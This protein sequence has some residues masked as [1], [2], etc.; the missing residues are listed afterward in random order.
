[1]C[2]ASGTISGFAAPNTTVVISG[3]TAAGAPTELTAPRETA[4][5]PPGAP[6]ARSATPGIGAPATHFC[7]APGLAISRTLVPQ[8]VVITWRAVGLAPGSQAGVR[9]LN[10]SAPSGSR[11]LYLGSTLVSVL[12]EAS[13]ILSGFAAAGNTTLVISGTTAAGAP[14]ELTTPFT[15]AATG[16]P[17]PAAPPRPPSGIRALALD[18]STIRLDWIDNSNN[19]TGFKIDGDIAGQFTAPADSSTYYVPGLRAAS[20]YCFAIS[21]FNSSGESFGGRSCAT[22]PIH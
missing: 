2:E 3:T 18:S 22:T 1:L 4:P 12:C 9:L 17:T 20:Y 7:D 11:D 21:A 8:D 16:Q 6:P 14:T 5:L 13:G 19:E 10:P 15:V